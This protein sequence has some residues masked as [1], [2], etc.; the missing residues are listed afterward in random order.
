MKKQT[1]RRGLS[2][3]ELVTAVAILGVLAAMAIDRLTSADDNADKQ[4]CY[5]QK[6]QIEVQCQLFKRNTGAFPTSNLSNI[7][8]NTMYF[9]SGLP[10]CPVDASAYTINTTTGRISGHT[11]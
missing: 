1:V 11:H 5:C 9:P 7:S 2:L 8:G 4:A 6:S 3:M 10:I